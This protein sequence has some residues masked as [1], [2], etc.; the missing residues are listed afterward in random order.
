MSDTIH[1]TCHSRAGV[2]SAMAAS[3]DPVV[4]SIHTPGATPL[5]NDDTPWVLTLSFDD[6]DTIP[7]P[8]PSNWDPRA[9]SLDDAR[10]V[11]C[12]IRD[13]IAARRSRIIVHCDAGM[14]R[15]AGIAAALARHYNGDDVWFFENKTPNRLVYRTVL[16]AL[17]EDQ[18]TL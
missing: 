12:F 8:P 17:N 4:V 16:D 9:F 14:S 5:W 7:Y 13:A 6:I 2:F 11:A 1:V 18:R 3:K 10:R 15:S